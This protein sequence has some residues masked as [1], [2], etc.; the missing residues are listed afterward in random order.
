MSDGDLARLERLAKETLDFS[1]RGLIYCVNGG[2]HIDLLSSSVL[3]LLAEVRRLNE[4]NRLSERADEQLRIGLTNA[5]AVGMAMQ[6][7]NDTGEGEM[8]P[9]PCAD[10]LREWR[11]LKQLVRE[12]QPGRIG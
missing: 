3:C 6:L 5:G 12:L 9:G 8:S 4:A 7:L 11:R 1:R 2:N 10:A